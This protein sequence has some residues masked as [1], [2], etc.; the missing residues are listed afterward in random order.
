MKRGMSL[1]KK[2]KSLDFK[3]VC[4]SSGCGDGSCEAA[5][6]T[7]ANNSNDVSACCNV[8]VIRCLNSS[9]NNDLNRSPADDSLNESAILN[10][11]HAFGEQQK[12]SKAFKKYKFS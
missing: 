1:D 8:K 7:C 5:T 3:D 4:E 11:T 2:A 9:L 12:N 6:P 10:N